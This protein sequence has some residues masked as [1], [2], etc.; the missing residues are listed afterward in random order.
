MRLHHAPTLYKN[1]VR[2]YLRQLFQ[3]AELGKRLIL[4]VC[5]I[6]PVIIIPIVSTGVIFDNFYGFNG[7]EVNK[8]YFSLVSLSPFL[9]IW[10]LSYRLN[11]KVNF[12]SKIALCDCKAFLSA[13]LVKRDTWP[14]VGWAFLFCFLVWAWWS[15]RWACCMLYCHYLW[16]WSCYV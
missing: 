4:A 11:W 16:G 1:L 7:K 13:R 8:M 9:C 14:Y 3:P 5:V 12:Y 15:M 2:I 6:L 10:W